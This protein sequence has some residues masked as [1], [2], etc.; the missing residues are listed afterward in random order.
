M[1]Y[2]KLRIQLIKDGDSNKSTFLQHLISFIA[3]TFVIKNNN[4]KRK[5]TIYYTRSSDQSFVNYIVKLALSGVSTSIGFKNN[6][7]YMKQYKQELK[8]SNLPPLELNQHL[9]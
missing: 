8:E 9:K 2:R 3:N 7:K 4:T 6:R 5:G 1:H